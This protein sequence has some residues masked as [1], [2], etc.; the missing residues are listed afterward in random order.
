MPDRDDARLKLQAACKQ[1]EHIIRNSSIKS[2]RVS[3]SSY[4]GIGSSTPLKPV[5]WSRKK[6]EQLRL[7]LVESEGYE[8][9]EMVVPYPPGIPILYP[10]EV[11]T[12]EMIGYISTL[13]E[14]GAKFQGAVDSRMQTIAVYS[15]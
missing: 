4:P 1:I 3:T 12:K 10:G 2:V 13:A 15:R 5:E 14:T 11:L 7:P 8:V 6:R 9:A